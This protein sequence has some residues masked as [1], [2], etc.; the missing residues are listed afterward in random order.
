M[1]SCRS[2]HTQRWKRLALH[3]TAITA[4]LW[5]GNLL[6][7]LIESLSKALVDAVTR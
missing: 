1:T 3:P 5:V 7:L 6:P 2:R 4:N